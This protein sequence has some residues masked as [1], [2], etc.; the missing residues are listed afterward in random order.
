MP[1]IIEKTRL[2]STLMSPVSTG[3]LKVIEHHAVTGD[4]L[5]LDETQPDEN[6]PTHFITSA[7]IGH[8]R[9]GAIH[10]EVRNR[11]APL[12]SWAA[13]YRRYQ[14]GDADIEAHDKE[15][16]PALPEWWSIRPAIMGNDAPTVLWVCGSKPPPEGSHALGENLTTIPPKENFWLC[17]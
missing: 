14:Q 3:R 12:Q 1:S 11:K 17:R 2:V 15:S 6:H 5:W 9:Q 16:P 10:I 8:I 7:H 13:A 4:W